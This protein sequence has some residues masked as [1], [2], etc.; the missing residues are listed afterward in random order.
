MFNQVELESENNSTQTIR[1]ALIGDT[2]TGKT[3]MVTSYATEQFPPEY[4]PTFLDHYQATV[5]VEGN[6]LRL[7]IWDTSGQ[8][9]Y[10]KLREFSYRKSDI[11][12]ICFAVI[13][14]DSFRNVKEKV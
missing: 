2:A 6:P 9:E 8:D 11:F 13:D 10:K 4:L 7:S 14:P 3:V 5:M 12:M 1:C